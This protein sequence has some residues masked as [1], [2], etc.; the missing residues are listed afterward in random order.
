MN[1]KLLLTA[2][3]VIFGII[4][5]ALSFLPNEIALFL[6]GKSDV[7][8][9]I[10]LQL[11]G[12]LY[13]GFAMINWMAKG[14]IIGGIYNKPI[15]VGNFMHFG[16]GVFALMKIINSLELH[17]EIFILLMIIRLIF[18]LIKLRIDIHKIPQK[19]IILV[20]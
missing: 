14:S 11:I 20:F 17:R 13:L 8:S 19:K 2:C 4:G 1:T 7:I 6:N 10:L 9:T 16:V 3:A 18:M 12:A 15:A 5:L